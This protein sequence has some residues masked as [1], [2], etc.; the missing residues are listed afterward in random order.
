M[1]TKVLSILFLLLIIC[2]FSEDFRVKEVRTID[3]TDETASHTIQLGMMEAL[4]IDLAD[5]RYFMEAIEMEVSLP[6][7]VAEHGPAI[8]YTFYKDVSPYPTSAEIDYSAEKINLDTFM[9]KRNYHFTIP[10]SKEYNAKID[11]YTTNISL[12]FNS[13]LEDIFMRLHIIMKGVPDGLFDS[14]VTVTLKPVFNNKGLLDLSILY[15]ENS[16]K[17]FENYPYLVFIDEEQVEFSG[18][19]ILLEKGTH[20]LAVSSDYFRSKVQTFDIGRATVTDISV[21]LQD[22]APLLQITAPKD[23]VLYLN[24]T[25]YVDFINPIEV[26]PGSHTLQ[27]TVGDYEILKTIDVVNA[28]TYNVRLDFDITVTEE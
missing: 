28:R 12:P 4:Y 17:N 10:V 16:T 1:K 14:F 18:E 23:T 19:S 3:W 24:D 9:Y 26:T 25:E 8:A 27:F 21:Q 5:T 7:S 22:I 2:A 20:H 6:A 15:P 11:P 13:Q